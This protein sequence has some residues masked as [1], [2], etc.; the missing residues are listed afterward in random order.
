MN[1]LGKL[2][3]LCIEEITYWQKPVAQ[4]QTIIESEIRISR[5]WKKIEEHRMADSDFR[6][7]ILIDLLQWPRFIYTVTTEC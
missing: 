1:Q 4:F 6:F 5:F 7:L 3:F 2:K